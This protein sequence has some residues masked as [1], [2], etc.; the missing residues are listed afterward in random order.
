MKQTSDK[1]SLTFHKSTA[2][3]VAG[4]AIILALAG[5]LFYNS[6]MTSVTTT[7]ATINKI[8]NAGDNLDPREQSFVDS[9]A[10]G[11]EVSLD[12]VEADLSKTVIMDEDF[13]D[14]K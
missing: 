14:I 5:F 9:Q 1:I 10:T 2:Y 11:N 6:S 4:A 3:K 7:P 8:G 13:S 12:A